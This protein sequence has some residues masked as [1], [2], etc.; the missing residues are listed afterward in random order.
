MF[1]DPTEEPHLQQEAV[2]RSNQDLEAGHIL[3]CPGFGGDEQG[4]GIF[5]PLENCNRVTQENETSEEPGSIMCWA[6]E[7][8]AED[9]RCR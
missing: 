3:H 6:E 8:D 1:Q 2:G 5:L 9:A 4:E 7:M